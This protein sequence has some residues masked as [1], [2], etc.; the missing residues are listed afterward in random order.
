MPRSIDTEFWVEIDNGGGTEFDAGFYADQPV[1]DV[2]TDFYAL[3][4][5]HA[6]TEVA[7]GR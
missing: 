4:A 5:Q 2:D 7:H 6:A 3:C 1:N